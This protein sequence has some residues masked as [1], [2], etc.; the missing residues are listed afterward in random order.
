MPS[1]SESHPQHAQRAQASTP[2][3]TDLDSLSLDT[4]S[5]RESSA[6]T[7]I[8]TLGSFGDPRKSSGAPY[9]R[10][11]EEDTVME[12][13]RPDR[14]QSPQHA[15]SPTFKKFLDLPTA[16]Q[17][18]IMSLAH[19]CLDGQTFRP[20]YKQ[21]W[22][23]GYIVSKSS[24][25]DPFTDE[26]TR[27]SLIFSN[28]VD[29]ATPALVS[30][31]Y[32][33][34]YL[35]AFYS[36]NQFSFDDPRAAKWFF[37]NIGD[38]FRHLRKINLIMT[39]GVWDKNFIFSPGDALLDSSLEE[40][41]YGVLCWLQT[42]HKLTYLRLCLREIP[43]EEELRRGYHSFRLKEAFVDGMKLYR[44][45]ILLK[46]CRA[47]GIDTVKIRDPL[48]GIFRDEGDCLDVALMMQQKPGS[49]PCYNDKRKT[50]LSKVLKDMEDKRKRAAL[51]RELIPEPLHDLLPEFGT[52]EDMS[53]DDVGQHLGQQ[54]APS[55]E[56]RK[57]SKSQKKR[58]RKRMSKSQ[59]EQ[60]AQQQRQQQQRQPQ[61]Q[62]QQS[63]LMSI[64]GSIGGDSS[65]DSGA[66]GISRTSG[67]SGTPRTPGG[68]QYG[69][70]RQR[71]KVYG[72]RRY[73]SNLCGF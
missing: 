28:N 15:P 57:L 42:R 58:L 48:C 72:K 1:T 23:K 24:K 25:L 31:S 4:D 38:Q 50:P 56:W 26:E 65:T 55:T 61:P 36:R 12:D 7:S 68:L 45:K 18:D 30:K 32:A 14:S 6:P 70:G 67:A 5:L 63:T 62:P 11:L 20:H 27:E 49:S 40:L 46:L 54:Q 60:N 9:D 3:D 71:Q 43:T 47:W 2:V 29:I 16:L 64:L 13:G 34:T 73:P 66:S 53:V 19:V 22:A 21:G 69:N 52:E 35:E 41:W 17:I 39:L 44:D 10:D 37:T 33:R 59:K 8:T 51:E